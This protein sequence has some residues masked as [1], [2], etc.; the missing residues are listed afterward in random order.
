MRLR[1]LRHC[2]SGILLIAEVPI[3]VGSRSIHLTPSLCLGRVLRVHRDT[4]EPQYTPGR[5]L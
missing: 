2:V 3:T 4:M 1:E 5:I